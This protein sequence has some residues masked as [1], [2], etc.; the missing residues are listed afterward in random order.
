ME[1][2][3]LLVHI[4]KAEGL[5]RLN[6][7]TG[8]HPYCVC[9]VKNSSGQAQGAQMTT[10]P[11]MNGD[12]LNPI[13]DEA[14]QVEP[15]QPGDTLEFSIYD[16]GL[17]GAKTQGKA[18]LSAEDI[19][20]NGFA[21]VL[22]ISGLAEAGLYVEVQIVGMSMPEAQDGGAL[23]GGQAQV[24]QELPIYPGAPTEAHVET[25]EGE[26]PP[27]DADGAAPSATYSEIKHTAY[28]QP[29]V[30]QPGFKLA[31]SILQAHGLKHMNHFTGDEVYAVCEVKRAQLQGESP[32]ITTKPVTEDAENPFWGETEE[33]GPIYEGDCLEFTVYDKGLI[34]AQTEGKGVLPCEVFYP[35]GYS[36]MIQLSGSEHTMI[37]VIVRP[38]GIE[39]GQDSSTVTKSKK[40]SKKLKT[41]KKGKKC[42]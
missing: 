31:V 1:A 9:E 33:M 23:E 32:K 7:F 8:D 19:Q 14:F 2:P 27:E 16:K 18:F 30:S 20:P 4:I 26:Q 6:H 35:N 28:N 41:S 10:K 29:E 40:K 42:C 24:Y 12:T 25:V 34:S 21:G 3:K 15:W 37:H 39:P 13:W 38:L 17:L 22:S 36:G 5:K 11:V